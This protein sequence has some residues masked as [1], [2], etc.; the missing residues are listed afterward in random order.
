MGEQDGIWG[1]IFTITWQSVVFMHKY[2][3]RPMKQTEEPINSL[4]IW[5]MRGQ[6]RSMGNERQIKQIFRTNEI[7]SLLH[8]INNSKRIKC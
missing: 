5:L 7:K 1:S 2:V 6:F 4:H 8:S 3:S